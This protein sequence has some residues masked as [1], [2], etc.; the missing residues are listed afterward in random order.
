MNFRK[1]TFIR[2][3]EKNT[4]LKEPLQ[5]PFCL[6]VLCQNLAFLLPPKGFYAGTTQA[7]IANCDTKNNK[8]EAEH[9]FNL[10]HH[11]FFSLL[12]GG[13]C[14]FYRGKPVSFTNRAPSWIFEVCAP[15]YEPASVKIKRGEG[16]SPALSTRNLAQT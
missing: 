13:Y 8:E 14:G 4:A 5:T 3:G 9:S 10:G 11:G 12:S 15:R 16:A 7:C 2:K 1:V 6:F